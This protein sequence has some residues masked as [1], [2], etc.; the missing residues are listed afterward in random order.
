MSKKMAVTLIRRII[1]VVL[2]LISFI[3]ACTVVN[4]LWLSIK[5]TFDFAVFCALAVIAL[6]GGMVAWG[7]AYKNV[8]LGVYFIVFGSVQL[9]EKV[10]MWPGNVAPVAIPSLALIGVGVFLIKRKTPLTEREHQ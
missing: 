7:W 10:F 6:L 9:I 8:I 1:A 4:Q 2:L 3:C 5:D